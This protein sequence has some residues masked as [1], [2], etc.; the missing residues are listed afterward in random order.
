MSTTS[1]AACWRGRTDVVGIFPN[2]DSAVRLV[3]AVLSEQNDEWAV[4]RRYR[5]ALS[6]KRARMHVIDGDAE[7]QEVTTQQRAG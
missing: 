2:R 4:T 5:D 6:L 1:S 3:A 7:T